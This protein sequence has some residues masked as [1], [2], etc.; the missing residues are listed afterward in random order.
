MF[1][2]VGIYQS[3]RSCVALLFS[4]IVKLDSINFMAHFSSNNFQTDSACRQLI[5]GSHDYLIVHLH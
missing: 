5:A 2:H 4:L 3:L 1:I